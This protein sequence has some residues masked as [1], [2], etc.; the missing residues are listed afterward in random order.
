VQNGG[1]IFPEVKIRTPNHPD[2]A[3]ARNQW[4]CNCVLHGYKKRA[5]QL[6]HQP[7]GTC[8]IIKHQHLIGPCG[9]GYYLDLLHDPEAATSLSQHQQYGIGC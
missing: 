3:S 4:H 2:I 8:E 7:A 5:N 6:T 9:F 1:G